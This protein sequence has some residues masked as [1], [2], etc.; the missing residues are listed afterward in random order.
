MGGFFKGK[1]VQLGAPAAT[2]AKKLDVNF[3]ADDFF[4]QMMDD[5]K[6]KQMAQPE[7][8][9]E[10]PKV[11]ES[12]PSFSMTKETSFVVDDPKPIV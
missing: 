4:S 10:E 2:G 5:P 6:P 3:D 11:E 8:K 12:K 9:V 1:S 7:K